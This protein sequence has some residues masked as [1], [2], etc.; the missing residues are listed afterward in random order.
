MKVE[1]Q[2]PA[3]LV[4]S[5]VF[6]GLVLLAYSGKIPGETLLAL[7]AWLIPSP[8][9]PKPPAPPTPPGVH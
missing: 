2:W 8:M 7:I 1:W 4:F 9:Q 5:T 6:A 3:A